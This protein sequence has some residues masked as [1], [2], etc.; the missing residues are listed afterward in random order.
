M[1]R[2]GCVRAVARNY[3]P[4]VDCRFGDPQPAQLLGLGTRDSVKRVGRQVQTRRFRFPPGLAGAA[5]ES[6]LLLGLG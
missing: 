4:L 6:D 3:L 1:I 2:V 5:T